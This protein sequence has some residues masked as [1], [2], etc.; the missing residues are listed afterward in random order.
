MQSLHPI[1]VNHVL[2]FFNIV[3]VVDSLKFI[4]A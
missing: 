3:A 4:P 2:V 1:E